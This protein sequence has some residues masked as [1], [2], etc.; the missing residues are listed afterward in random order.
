MTRVLLLHGFLGRPSTWTRV[1]ERLTRVTPMAPHLPGHGPAS[2][3]ARMP[4]IPI[5][6][7]ADNAFEAAAEQLLQTILRMPDANQPTVVVGYSMGARLAL[8]LLLRWQ[9][10]RDDS[11]RGDDAYC[12]GAVLIGVNPGLSDDERPARLAWEQALADELKRGGLP[13]FAD[14]WERLPLF[15]SQQS[16]GADVLREERERRR[17]HTVEGLAYALSTLGLAVQPNYWPRL[18]ELTMPITLIA[19]SAD[20]KFRALHER[21]AAALPSARQCEI[22]GVG[23]NVALEAP[24]LV[25]DAVVEHLST[26]PTLAPPLHDDAAYRLA[27]SIK[28]QETTL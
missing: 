3:V 21:I 7:G 6:G 19:G 11:K 27:D 25:A 16:L 8:A 9:R 13:A 10:Y 28:I 24:T 12:A 20:E 5:E 14:E 22:A 17:S 15:A 1:I 4:R 26:L 18:H 23:H 2:L